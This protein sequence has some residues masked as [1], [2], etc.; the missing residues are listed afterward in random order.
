[1]RLVTIDGNRMQLE[2]EADQSRVWIDS[3]RYRDLDW[4]YAITAPPRSGVDR[5]RD[6]DLRRLE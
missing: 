1:M 5:R 2:R 4:G 3:D 6:L